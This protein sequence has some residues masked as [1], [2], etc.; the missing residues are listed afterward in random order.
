MAGEINMVQLRRDFLPKM[1]VR[2]HIGKL[3]PEMK[4]D[5]V[6]AAVMSTTEERPELV[7]SV[8]RKKPI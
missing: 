3:P 4:R 8:K 7:L 6:R 5:W 1:L 2:I